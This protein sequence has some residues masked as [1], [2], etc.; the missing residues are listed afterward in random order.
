M[1]LHR[2]EHA[3]SGT[4]ATTAIPAKLHGKFSIRTVP[5]MD[6][7]KVE[8]LVRK[9]IETKF[10][11]LQSKNDL[12]LSCVHQ[13]DWFF[14]DASHWNYRAAVSAT[15]AVWSVD[16]DIACEGGRFERYILHR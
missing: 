12:A 6:S 15:K 11:S 7:T 4:G 16:P 13:S 2:I 8:K 3:K 14:E 9:Y 5:D 1:S 10:A